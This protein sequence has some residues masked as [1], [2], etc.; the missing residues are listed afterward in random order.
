M[1]SSADIPGMLKGLKQNYRRLAEETNGL[2][3]SSPVSHVYNPLLYART[4]FEEY[5]SFCRPGV[6]FLLVGM[7]P[8]PWGMV[9]TGVPFGDAD[10]VR[11]WLQ[12]KSVPLP[13]PAEHPARPVHGPRCPRSEVS[14]RRLW[15]W[16]QRDFGTPEEFF[17]R[18]FVGNYCPLA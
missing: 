16:A 3:F 18:F 5:L 9:Q 11:N 12:I 4:P 8:G 14:G 15:G 17:S 6:D 13:P 10:M 7:N 2:S 1:S